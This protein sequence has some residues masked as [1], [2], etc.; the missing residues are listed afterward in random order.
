MITPEQCRA[1]RGWLDWSQ[2][3]LA[4]RANVSLSTVRDYE[5]GR[6]IPISNNIIAIQTALERAGVRLTESEGEP[7]GIKYE[8]RIR[9][10][11]TYKP[12]LELL[13]DMP[14]GFMTTADLIRALEM[15]MAPNGEDAEILENRSD[16]RFSQ[17]VRNVVSHRDVPT[18]L[19][20]S[21][22]ADYD[23][24]KRGLRITEAGRWHLAS[25]EN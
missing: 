1:A 5:K 21:G 3:E 4:Q 12:I 24:R 23:R 8:H 15:R 20:G 7:T 13:D 18:N 19:I 6:R 22:L 11:D 2:E 14:G 10:R 9:E 25:E 17:I 16:T